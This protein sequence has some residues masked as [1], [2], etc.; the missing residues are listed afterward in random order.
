MRT[1]DNLS[2]DASQKVQVVI[3]DGSVVEVAL[4]YLP[5]GQRWVA[6]ITRDDFSVKSLGLCFHPNLLRQYRNLIPFGL[7]CSAVDGV[8]PAYIQDWVNGRCSLQVLSPADV[9]AIE[10]QVFEEAS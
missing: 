8:D 9:A 6:D 7:M 5:S 4:R 3:D 10:E 1:I 2:N